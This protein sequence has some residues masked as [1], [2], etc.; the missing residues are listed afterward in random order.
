LQDPPVSFAD[1]RATR[2]AATVSGIR[3]PDFASGDELTT[4]IRR[5][6]RNGT[7]L[8]TAP[9][10]TWSVIVVDQRA[11]AVKASAL[12]KIR[13]VRRLQGSYKNLQI[14]SKSKSMKQVAGRMPPDSAQRTIGMVS[15]EEISGGPSHERTGLG[16]YRAV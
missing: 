10:E 16:E 4:T 5:M 8:P 13:D 15:R 11:S 2:A 3:A 9:E 12:V 6:V 1:T 14:D 7:L